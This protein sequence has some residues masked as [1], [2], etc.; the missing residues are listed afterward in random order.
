MVAF[1]ADRA[2]VYRGQCAEFCGYQ[3]AKMALFVIADEPGAWQRWADGQRAPAAA[4]RSPQ[5]A[6]GRE[7][8]ETGTCAMCH[9]VGGTLAGGRR[10]PDLTHVASRLTLAA[11]ALPNEVG[12]RAAWILDPQAIKPGVNMPAT[13]LP[14][15]DAMAIAAFLGSLK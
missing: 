10:A 2:G 3:H 8:F 13:R 15:Q 6:R 14:P 5:E 7:M 12:A 9:A 1:R 4:A 11:G